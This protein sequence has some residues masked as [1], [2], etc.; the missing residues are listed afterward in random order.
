MLGQRTVSEKWDL[1]DISPELTDALAE[2]IGFPADV[3]VENLTPHELGILGEALAGAFLI[4]NGYEILEHGYR[5]REGEAD[6][7][8]YDPA[9]E[10]IVLVEVKTR[11]ALGEH[12]ELCSGWTPEDAVDEDKQRRYE[13][14]A[15]VFLRCNPEVRSIR[16]DVVALSVTGFD[17]AHIRY[18]KNAFERP[19]A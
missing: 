13:L 11:L 7:G 3:A 1:G 8:A 12:P 4:S 19:G 14:L 9:D 17:R 18:I 16:F 10:C 5:C 2:D 6:Y 15:Q